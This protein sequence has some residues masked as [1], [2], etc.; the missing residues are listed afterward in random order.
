LVLKENVLSSLIDFL[1]V[2]SKHD[3]LASLPHTTT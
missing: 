3:K 1:Y 2:R